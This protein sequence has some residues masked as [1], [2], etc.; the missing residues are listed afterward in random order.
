MATWKWLPKHVE[1]SS[2]VEFARE[3]SLGHRRGACEPQRGRP[4]PVH[5]AHRQ[6]RPAVKLRSKGDEEACVAHEPK[7]ST[8][9]GRPGW[10]ADQIG[11]GQPVYM[12][13][14]DAAVHANERPVRVSFLLRQEARSTDRAD[15]D[16]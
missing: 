7:Q 9:D 2:Q 11:S 1:R 12:A 3:A 15:P 14:T 16:G 13:E 6:D 10:R 8:P 5:S 4:E